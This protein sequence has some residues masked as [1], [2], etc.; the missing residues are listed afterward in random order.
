MFTRFG[1]TRTGHCGEHSLGQLARLSTSQKVSVSDAADKPLFKEILLKPSSWHIY[2][3]APLPPR[4]LII[5]SPQDGP[6]KDSMM[7][8]ARADSPY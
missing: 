2:P 7:C 5:T 6:Y 1:V 3:A 8:F 4:F